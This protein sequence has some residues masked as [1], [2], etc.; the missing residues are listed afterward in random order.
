MAREKVD[1]PEAVELLPSSALSHSGMVK[2]ES[3][4]VPVISIV[5]SVSLPPAERTSA[6][7]TPRVVGAAAK[8]ASPAAN[9]EGTSGRARSAKPRQGVTARMA[10]IPQTTPGQWRSA[11]PM[12]LVLSERPAIKKTITMGIISNRRKGPA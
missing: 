7:P 3:R 10:T 6:A 9:S 4:L 2:T 1:P 12:S 5:A 11:F 8:M